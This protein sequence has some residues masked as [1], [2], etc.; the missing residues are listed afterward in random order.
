MKIKSLNIIGLITSILLIGF[1]YYYMGEIQFLRWLNN[2]KVPSLLNSNSQ[3]I[4][5]LTF[6]IGIYSILFFSKPYI[7]FKNKTLMP[8]KSLRG[9]STIGM[10]ITTLIFIYNVIMM[11]S[12]SHISFDEVGYAWLLYGVLSAV[13][14]VIFIIQ[15]NLSLATARQMK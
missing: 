10:V 9:L 15:K 2:G 12:P 8:L 13:I 6:K 4:G 11:L 14:F 7:F 1:T 5:S 3:K